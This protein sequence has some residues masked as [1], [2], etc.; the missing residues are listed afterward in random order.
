MLLTVMPYGNYVF[1]A[2]MTGADLLAALNHGLS[3]PGAGAFPQFYGMSVTARKVSQTLADG[4]S[5]DSFV[6]EEVNIGGNPLA[7]DAKYKVAFSDFLYAGGDDYTWFAKYPYREFGTL[8]DM[9]RTFLI[10][11]D[12]QTIRAIDATEVLTIR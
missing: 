9:F 8:E 11:S 1:V 3:R 2:E 4:T 12:A 6:A 7:P 10:E 5:V